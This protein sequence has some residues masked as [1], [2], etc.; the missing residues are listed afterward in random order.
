MSIILTAGQAGN[1]PQL[2]PLLDQLNVGRDGPGRPRKRPDRIL[3]DKT[4][5]AVK[6]SSG[7]LARVDGGW[8][9]RG[10]LVIGLVGVEAVVQAAQ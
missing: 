7:D 9:E 1:N 6:L 10:V 3:A 5:H 4:S 2:L 8:R